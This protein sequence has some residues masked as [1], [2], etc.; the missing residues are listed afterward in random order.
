MKLQKETKWLCENSRA[1]ERFAGKWVAFCV[2]EGL[3]AKGASLDSILRC[4]KKRKLSRRS[5]V[6]HVPSKDELH[7]PFPYSERK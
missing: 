2:N 3:V 1:L 4:A 6:F 7:I 5:F